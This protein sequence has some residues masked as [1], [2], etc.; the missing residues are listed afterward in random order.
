MSLRPPF[1]TPAGQ[2]P[3]PEI[4][5]TLPLAERPIPSGMAGVWLT[6]EGVLTHRLA[7]RFGAR[8]RL[9]VLWQGEAEGDPVRLAL[10]GVSEGSRLFGRT[11]LLVVQGR[12]K[13]LTRMG[14]PRDGWR[15]EVWAGIVA[16]D[17]PIG[18]WLSSLGLPPHR[19]SLAIGEAEV[20]GI[21]TPCPGRRHILETGRPGLNIVVEEIFLPGTIPESL[22]LP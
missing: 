22:E 11:G 5:W 18:E 2:D 1:T 19:R 12:P 15:P 10:L 14:L 6:D 20:P 8:A 17:Q 9:E 21:D 3:W 4:L 16:G 7:D 13:V